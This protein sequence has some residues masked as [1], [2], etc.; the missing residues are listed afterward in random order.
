M[1]EGDGM[2]VWPETITYALPENIGNT[3][4]FVGRKKE[5]DYFLGE[6]Y[7]YL[8]TNMAQSQA[9][10]ARRKKGKTAFLQRLFNILWSCPESGVVPFYYSFQDK[11]ITLSNFAEDFFAAFVGQY[12]SYRDRK[13]EYLSYPI[14]FEKLAPLIQGDTHL[15]DAYETMEALEKKG[16][17]GRMWNTASRLPAAIAAVKKIKIVQILDEFQ[18]ING[19]IYDEQWEKLLPLSGTYLDLAE[20]REAPLIVSGSEVHGLMK[21]VRALTRRFSEYLLENLPEDEARQAIR[22]Y[23]QATHTKIDDQGVEKLWNLTQGDP[24][25]INALFT[26]KHNT[27]KDFTQEEHIVETYS[28]EITRGDIYDTWI[29][30]IAKV[31]QE[32]NQRN[33]KRIMLYLFHA[34]EERTRMQILD[35]LKLEMT[36]AQL[37]EKLYQLIKAD[38]ISQG[39]T[40]YDYKISRD[41]TYE[42][43]FRRIYQ[44]EIEHFVP[45]IQQEIRKAM[46]KASNT[47]GKYREFLIKEALKKP[48]NLMDLAENGMDLLIRPKEIQ[49]RQRV[50]IG[51][52]EREIDLIVKGNHELWIDIK[53]TKNKYGKSETDRWLEIKGLAP[54]QKKPILFAVYSQSGYTQSALERL[55]EQGVFVLPSAQ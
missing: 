17:A 11:P 50:K 39:K 31:F 35:D 48:F 33:A 51:V 4:L 43:V 22:R 28:Q 34:G 24:L 10:V 41:T 19:F 29:E 52:R 32:V 5:F 20:K 14:S 49:Q 13:E 30:Y 38:L 36:D 21:I 8:Q 47:M 23:A 27:T 55:K 9:V 26:T 6:W 1:K 37:E 54:Q 40:N 42:L 18:N 53:D 25:Y 7:D 16:K 45:N 3:D 46:G 12:L 15:S 2:F 44:K